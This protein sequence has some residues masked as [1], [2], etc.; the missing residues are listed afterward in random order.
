[1]PV[2][3]L[4]AMEDKKMLR[5]VLNGYLLIV[6]CVF[7]VD[8]NASSFS[9]ESEINARIIYDDNINLYD[10]NVSSTI[11]EES[12]SIVVVEPK[13]KLNYHSGGW[14]TAM[15]AGISGATYSAQIQDR[16]NGHLDLETAYKDNR[17]IYSISA[18]YDVLSHRASDETFIG[19][20]SE[21][22]KTQKLTLAPKYTHLLTERLSLSLDY[23]YSDVD[24]NPNELGRYLP[25][26][27]Q[28][29][30]GV[31]AY[32]LS[33]KSE[34]SLALAAIDYTSENNIS[35]YQL[36]SS[37]FGIA[38]N[39]S[40][41]ISAKLFAGF[42]TRD[43]TTG[44]GIPFD[45]FG[46]T[47]TGAPVETSSNGNLFEASV[48]AKWIELLAS[49]DT[50]S[51]DTGGLDQTDKLRAKLRMQVTSLIGITLVLERKDIDEIND[52]IVDQSRTVTRIIPAMNFSLARDLKLRAGYLFEEYKYTSNQLGTSDKNR[53]FV[54][55]TY[56][57]PS[58]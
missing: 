31:M 42:N 39:F 23:S 34:L 53:F 48:D 44:D 24:Y 52:N 22:T 57:F 16:I 11:D 19:L 10:S 56:H 27:T 58:I 37:K 38:H 3:S 47:V 28:T 17:S 9:L 15:N 45:F 7:V 26:E 13:M 35:E 33:Q 43:F 14:D 54:N 36:L 2:I 29:A 50:E 49:R 18:A 25:Y 20:V 46:T 32:K 5:P 6:F 21:R 41:T 55:L 12:S 1:M 8:A 51:N 4:I 40:E 30:T